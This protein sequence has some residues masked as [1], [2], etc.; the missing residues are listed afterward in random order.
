MCINRQIDKEMVE[1]DT[2]DYLFSNENEPS[3]ETY[4]NMDQKH[5][6]KF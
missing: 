2:P 4:N 6:A 5:R 3:T 1:T